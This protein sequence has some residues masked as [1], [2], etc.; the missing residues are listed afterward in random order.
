MEDYQLMTFISGSA[1]DETL[2]GVKA[3]LAECADH[4]AELFGVEQTYGLLRAAAMSDER[5]ALA[6]EHLMKRVMEEE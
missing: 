3:W 2:A 4:G 6:E 5:L 1:S